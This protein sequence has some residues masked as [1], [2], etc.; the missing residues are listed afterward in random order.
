MKKREYMTPSM[1]VVEIEKVTLLAGSGVT[2][3]GIDYGGT[4]DNGLLD[5]D[6]PGLIDFGLPGFF[7]E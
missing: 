1:D 5:P 6:A 3:D 7:F 2:S 4:D